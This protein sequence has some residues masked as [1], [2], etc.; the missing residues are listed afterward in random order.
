MT[1]KDNH[2]NRY[3]EKDV[4][5]GHFQHGG[6]IGALYRGDDHA[7]II[8]M[9]TYEDEYGMTRE[10]DV[11]EVDWSHDTRS[12]SSTEKH[13]GKGPKNWPSD[14]RLR[15]MIAEKLFDSPQVDASCVEIE[16]QEGIVYLRGMVDT[17]AHKKAAEKCI[18]DVAG[19]IDIQNEIRI[20]KDRFNQ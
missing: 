4:R 16:V 1:S 2:Y 17:R 9:P 12:E 11:Q 14:E 10:E 18:E 6:G 15:Q 8:S 20:E 5:P 13:Y 19:V 3:G 7:A